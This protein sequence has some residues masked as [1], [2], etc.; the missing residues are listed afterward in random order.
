MAE[1]KSCIYE[2]EVVHQR[3]HPKKH[4][5]SYRVFSLCLDLD[6]LNT[7]DEVP[8]FSVN[9]FNLFSF[10]EED[11]G[12]GSGALA[13]QIRKLLQQRG[14]QSASSRI[15]LLCYPRV[16][17]YVFNPLSVYFCYN[18]DEQLEVILY[19]VSNTFG[20]R[21]IYLIENHSSSGLIKQ[22]CNKS[23]YVSPFMPM[24]T[25]YHFH[26]LPPEEQVCVAINQT[27][28]SAT[29][30]PIFHAAFSGKKKTL[31]RSSLAQL[32]C[33]YPLMTLKVIVA[34][35]WEA[36]RLWRKK[37]RIQPRNKEVTQTISWYSPNGDL[38]SEKL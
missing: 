11:H 26:I 10:R 27:E 30:K 25:R 19:E 33:K 23:M 20:S 36:F 24:D 6:E 35:H 4:R 7:L 8:F 16:L 2:G 18:A 3:F 28:L 9:R 12:D 22:S 15:E 21:H 5:F 34:I 17:G 38:Q 14:F 37:L 29:D 32:F 1:L 13:E 31:Q